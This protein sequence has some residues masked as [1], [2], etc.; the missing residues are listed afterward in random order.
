[1]QKFLF[2]LTALAL[3]AAAAPG[4][5]SAAIVNDATIVP[6]FANA[7]L[8]PG[9]EQAIRANVASDSGWTKTEVDRALTIGS[10]KDPKTYDA[11]SRMAGGKQVQLVLVKFTKRPKEFMCVLLV[12]D[13]PNMLPYLDSYRTA[14]KAAGLKGYQTD[15]PHLYRTK[16]KLASGQ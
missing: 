8:T 16:G 14:T 2:R 10:R 9:T 7:C 5:A 12:P 13:V 1:M 6:V 15:L 11:F 4:A 3:V